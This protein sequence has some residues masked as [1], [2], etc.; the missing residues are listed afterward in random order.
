MEHSIPYKPQQNGVDE[1]KN[2]SLKEMENCVLQEKNLSHSLW[3]EVVNCTSYV[4]NRVPHKSVIGAT[5]SK[6]YWGIILMSHTLEFLVP[7]LGPLFLWTRE[8]P[9]KPIVANAYCW[10][11]LKMQN[12]IN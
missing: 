8:R 5:P 6:H 1:R 11:M 3:A 12:H 2:R 4:D 10:D 9:S 7:K